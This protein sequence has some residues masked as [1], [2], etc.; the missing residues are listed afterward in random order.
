M[1]IGD[2]YLIDSELFARSIVMVSN[3]YVCC[4]LRESLE[5]IVDIFIGVILSCAI[6]VDYMLKLW[7]D[8]V[9]AHMMTM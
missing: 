3:F 4:L 8:I 1:F 7:L 2:V 9:V 6:M 5:C